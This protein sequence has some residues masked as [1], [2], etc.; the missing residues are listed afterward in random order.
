MPKIIDKEEKKTRILEASIRIFAEKGLNNTKIA[1]IANAADIGKGTVYEYFSSKDE[2]FRAS[3]WF[4]MGKINEILFQKLQHLSDPLEKLQAFFSAWME[5]LQGEYL[6]YLEIILDF[7]AEGMRKNKDSMTF[8]LAQFYDQ[9]R[10]FLADLL[11]EC[12]AIQEIKHV[13]TKVAASILLGSLDGLM[14]Q[15]I[16]DRSI[17]NIRVAIELFAKIFIQ[18]LKKP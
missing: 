12:I 9:Y 10:R 6:E 13:D 5:I 17:F 15:W 7:W 3:Y 8:D 14:I 16:M 18:G 2:I 1:D 11:E 4:F